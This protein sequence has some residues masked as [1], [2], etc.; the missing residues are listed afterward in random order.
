MAIT[1]PGITT[2]CRAEA[3]LTRGVL[4]GV[5]VVLIV[6]QDDMELEPG[7]LVIDDGIGGV[8]NLPDALALRMS[9]RKVKLDG[10]YV[11]ALEVLDHRWRWDG[12]TVGGEWNKRLPDGSVDE[13]TKKTPQELATLCLDALG[14]SGYSVAG[15]P[16][17]V[18]PYCDW[19]QHPSAR[20]CLQEICDATAC[21]VC[22]GEFAAVTIYAAGTGPDMPTVPGNT[23]IHPTMTMVRPAPANFTVI[24]GPKRY[25][26]KLKLDPFG[27][28]SDNSVT[29]ID[30]LSYKPA[31]GWG[32]ELPG[33]FEGLSAANQVLAKK[34]VWIV[35]EIAGQSDGSLD[36]PGSDVSVDAVSQYLPLLPA[37][38]DTDSYTDDSKFP[39]PP[40]VL[41]TFY[42][43]GDVPV[44]E[45]ADTEWLGGFDLDLE[46]GRVTFP[47]PIF[48]LGS[49]QVPTTPTLNLLT[50]YRVRDAAG[51]D[52]GSWEHLS[53]DG[54]GSGTGATLF[55][56][57]PELFDARQESTDYTH[58]TDE[59]NLY[60]A[61]FQAAYAD[62]DLNDQT[63]AG[64]PAG[65]LSGFVAQITV[66][67]SCLG[68]EGFT[69]RICRLEEL[70]PLSPSEIERK[71]KLISQRIAEERGL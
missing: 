59:A 45:A 52:E 58:G 27:F 48:S 8:L 49:D 21:Y 5:H 25:C 11:W 14:E 67:G 20:L 66:M 39:L 71:R 33:V 2:I 10:G 17:N 16:T 50:S 13:A 1:F 18:Y 7:T 41:G 19:R 65:S 31:S 22:G 43:Y 30:N 60:L 34:G 23:I 63:Y 12:P 3:V 35:Y 54:P 56:R 15:M 37:Q 40:K 38:V 57:R 55:I 46:R 69:T 68:D 26:T 24:G 62:N 9:M 44:D 42:N 51:D 70:A 6:P 64:I 28:E 53:V 4:P 61:L 36:V 29:G 47:V 32:A